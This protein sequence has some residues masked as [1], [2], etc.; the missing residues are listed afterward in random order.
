MC[1]REYLCPALA[2]DLYLRYNNKLLHLSHII[3]S[4]AHLRLSAVFGA[5]Y[6]IIK[7]DRWLWWFLHRKQTHRPTDKPT[8]IHR[9]T[10]LHDP[11]EL[12][13]IFFCVPLSLG[14]S[15]SFVCHSLGRAFFILRHFLLLSSIHRKERLL[16]PCRLPFL[17]A[18]LPSSASCPGYFVLSGA[19]YRRMHKTVPCVYK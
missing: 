4:L 12:G 15:L 2:A 17:S 5:I 3:L 14:S 18:C 7:G 11:S 19:P 8:T 1:N 16:S 9:H 10:H 13:A 6:C